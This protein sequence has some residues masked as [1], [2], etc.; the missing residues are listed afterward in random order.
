MQIRMPNNAT[1][2]DVCLGKDHVVM[3]THDHMI[4]EWGC[5]EASRRA[6]QFSLYELCGQLCT[7]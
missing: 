5:V 4:Y 1:V 6:A 2:R 7:Q 3:L